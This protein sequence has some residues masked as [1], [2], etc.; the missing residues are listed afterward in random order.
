MNTFRGKIE[1]GRFQPLDPRGFRLAFAKY[2]QGTEIEVLVRKPKRTRSG[3][4]NAYYWGVVI[5]LISADTGFSPDEAH[6]SLRV[7]FL[8]DM[9]GDMP[10][11]K[12][13]TELSTSEFMD[14]VAQI[15]RFAAEF[16][17]LY[18]PDPNE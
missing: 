1:N 10:K 6:D 17:D 7:K 5:D 8:T 2:K 11:V 16:L 9:T 14:Y 13:T 12:S 3:E 18:I 15:Q 4:Q